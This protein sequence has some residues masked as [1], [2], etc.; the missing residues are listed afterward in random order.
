MSKWSLVTFIILTVVFSLQSATLAL[1]DNAPY[2]WLAHTH[3]QMHSCLGCLPTG[4]LCTSLALG[5][6]IC[7]H[8]HQY[9]FMLSLYTFQQQSVWHIYCYSQFFHLEYQR[10]FLSRFT[11]T[12]HILAYLAVIFISCVSRLM[13]T[14]I[15]SVWHTFQWRVDWIPRKTTGSNTFNTYLHLRCLCHNLFRNERC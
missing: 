15:S 12:F 8:P 10:S 6:L 3:T 5:I 2:Q 9:S 4:L 14:R 7:T 1:T 13:H 11:V